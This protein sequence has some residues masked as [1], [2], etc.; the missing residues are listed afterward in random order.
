MR[1]QRLQQMGGE[2]SYGLDGSGNFGAGPENSG[3]K[4]KLQSEMRNIDQ[5]INDQKLND[6][7]KL[8]AVKRKADMLENQAKMREKLIKVAQAAGN[9]RESQDAVQRTIEVNDMY[10]EAIT[11]K[12]K[13]LDNI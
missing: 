12:L 1:A 13:I 2:V 8:D 6:Y 11:A 10:M 3:V 9:G 4:R 7:E 5:L